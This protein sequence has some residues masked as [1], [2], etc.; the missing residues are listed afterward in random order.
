MSFCGTHTHAITHNHS[1]H[2][3]KECHIQRY[4]GLIMLTVRTDYDYSYYCMKKES[5]SRRF[6]YF[7]K[8]MA[9]D[10]HI[11]NRIRKPLISTQR[12]L[13]CI[14]FLNREKK[15][16]IYYNVSSPLLLLPPTLIPSISFSLSLSLSVGC[17]TST[18]RVLCVSVKRLHLS[19]FC[20]WLI[21]CRFILHISFKP[22]FLFGFPSVEI[23]A[24]PFYLCYAFTC[25]L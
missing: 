22:A 6:I 12:V 18:L 4:F 11:Y 7:K 13:Q 20:Y 3:F 17:H 24:G 15:N 16:G 9:S 23:A 25:L 21:S 5:T 8:G 1:S 14:L 2:Y 19:A 10:T